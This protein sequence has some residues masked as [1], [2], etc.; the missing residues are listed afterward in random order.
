MHQLRRDGEQV[1][2]GVVCEA[3]P[4]TRGLHGKGGDQRCRGEMAGLIIIKPNYN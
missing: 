2:G 1:G 4:A 3:S